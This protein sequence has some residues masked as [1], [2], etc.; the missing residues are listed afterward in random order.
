MA[1]V[2]KRVRP[3][4]GKR[5]LITWE[6]RW[7]EPDGRQR[8]RAFTKR[9]DADRYATCIESSLLTGSYVD[10][11]A[12]RTTIGAYAEVWLGRQVQL[13]PRPATGTPRSSAPT[14]VRSSVTC[15]WAAWS[16]PRW[17]RG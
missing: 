4:P 8:K 9:L 14:S 6:T 16:A 17:P 1:S 7:R 5:D 15:R 2:Y 13:A 12:G 10:P 3:R 11:S